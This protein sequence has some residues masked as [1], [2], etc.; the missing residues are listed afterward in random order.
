[1]RG[2]ESVPKFRY[3]L[4]KAGV[5]RHRID[6]MQHETEA[7]NKIQVSMARMPGQ[8]AGFMNPPAGQKRPEA[9]GQSSDDRV[10]TRQAGKPAPGDGNRHPEGRCRGPAV[11]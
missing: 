7:E 8:P 3:P 4:G 2:R 9:E 11:R 5:E 6:D 1:M 10:L